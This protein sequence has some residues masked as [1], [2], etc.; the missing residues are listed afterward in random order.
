MKRALVAAVLVL[1]VAFMAGNVAWAGDVSGKV[2][3]IQINDRMMIL[4]DGTRLYWTE[5]I[6][7]SKDIKEGTVVKATYEPRD[8]KFV[9][10]KIEILK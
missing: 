10:T 8:G 1:A 2:K 7:V 3:V 5:S 4:E 6:T 9:L